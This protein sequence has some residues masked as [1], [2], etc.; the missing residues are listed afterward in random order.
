M[1]QIAATQ[2]IA[3]HG[4]DRGPGVE[5][6]HG[7]DR[8]PNCSATLTK[9]IAKKKSSIPSK[10][11]LAGASCP[12][13]WRDDFCPRNGKP[14]WDPGARPAPKSP[15][16]VPWEP[17][18]P[19]PDWKAIRQ[20]L[21]EEIYGQSSLPSDAMPEVRSEAQV[22]LRAQKEI[23]KTDIGPVRS[24]RRRHLVWRVTDEAEQRKGSN[25]TKTLESNVFF[26]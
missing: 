21:S 8:K 11:S 2:R 6:T 9:E 5:R 24:A 16:C 15:Y 1:D 22:E 17:L 13:D 12:W 26:T 4:A 18:P 14:R 20:R 3:P 10:S 7:A 23:K 19:E 25:A